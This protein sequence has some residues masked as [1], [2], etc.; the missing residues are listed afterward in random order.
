MEVDSVDD[1]S[2]WSSGRWQFITRNSTGVPPVP[3][4]DR[5]V[6]N[7]W[8]LW[9][10]CWRSQAAVS[11]RVTVHMKADVACLAGL[12]S[13]SKCQ[14]VKIPILR[15]KHTILHNISN[16][17]PCLS[18]HDSKKK[19]AATACPRCS[20]DWREAPLSFSPACTF[21]NR[22]RLRCRCPGTSCK[23]Q[24]HFRRLLPR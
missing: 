3:L 19:L 24:I 16:T 21:C 17:C 6:H 20:A 22:S 8:S 13:I 14:T 15:I 4:D 1:I 23:Q 10:Q 18:D 7:T 12:K 5:T 2:P 11:H 9:A